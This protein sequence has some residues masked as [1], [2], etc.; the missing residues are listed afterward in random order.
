MK[1]KKQMQRKMSEERILAAKAEVPRLLDAKVIREVKYSDW[2]T[3]VVLP[4]EEWEDENVHRLHRLEQSLQE[5]HI[6]TP[7]D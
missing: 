2:P 4:K 3:N 1:Q 7:K 6:P 5:R